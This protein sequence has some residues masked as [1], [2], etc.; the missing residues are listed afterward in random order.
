MTYVALRFG[1]TVQI[2]AGAWKGLEARVISDDRITGG[3]VKVWLTG[4]GDNAFER[5]YARRS[6]EIVTRAYGIDVED[7]DRA[8]AENARFDEA[9]EE[10]ADELARVLP[11]PLG[12]VETEERLDADAAMPVSLRKVYP[13]PDEWEKVI[14]AARASIPT[15][16]QYPETIVYLRAMEASRRHFGKLWARAAEVLRAAGAPYLA[17]RAAAWAAYG[18]RAEAAV[19][20]RDATEL[21]VRRAIEAARR[22]PSSDTMPDPRDSIVAALGIPSG[23]IPGGNGATNPGAPRVQPAAAILAL[24]KGDPD[25]QGGSVPLRVYTAVPVV[26]YGW[27]EALEPDEIE[28]RTAR[29]VVEHLADQ[30]DA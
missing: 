17:V 16:G 3:L 9:L 15:P 7:I 26:E 30:G 1:D 8:Y 29:E 12:D 5:S 18:Y 28:K 13:T 27:P 11:R 23:P 25:P 19:W 21:E 14:N 10:T 6:L 22:G 20:E 2:R 4:L 24:P